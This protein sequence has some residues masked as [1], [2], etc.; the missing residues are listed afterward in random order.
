MNEQKTA[1]RKRIRSL[2]KAVS[3]EDKIRRSQLILEKVETLMAFRDSQVVMVY[4]SMSD[5]VHTH[6]FV[7]KWADS[8]TIVLPV[9]KGD[10]LEL[11]IFTGEDSLIKGEHYGIL[12]PSGKIVEDANQI[13]FILVP[14][15]A[16]DKSN[17]RLGRG[18]AYYDKLLKNTHAHKAGICFGFQM[19]PQVP[20]DENDIPMDMVITED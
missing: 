11:R 10:E 8:K 1:L 5:E 20:V 12:E 18:K 4:W 14:G 13:D 19:V 7:K 15:V 17:N 16:F 9:V 3:A 2:K 6:D